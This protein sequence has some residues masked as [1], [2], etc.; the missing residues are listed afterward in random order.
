MEKYSV[1]ISGFEKTEID[2]TLSKSQF[3]LLEY[4]YCEGIIGFSIKGLKHW[5]EELEEETKKKHKI[6]LFCE[7]G[8]RKY[9]LIN[10]AQLELLKILNKYSDLWNEH[11]WLNYQEP[12]FKEIEKEELRWIYNKPIF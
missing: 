8:D 11:Y 7:Y 10:D 6:V 4:L 12:C 3:K 2:L 5:T 9:F 1:H